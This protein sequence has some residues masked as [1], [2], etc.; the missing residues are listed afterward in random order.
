MPENH[1]SLLIYSPPWPHSMLNL[2]VISSIFNF[3]IYPRGIKEV[4]LSAPSFSPPCLR[5]GKFLRHGINRRKRE[6]TCNQHD[7]W[8]IYILF[9]RVRAWLHMFEENGCSLLP[10]FVLVFVYVKCLNSLAFS[11]SVVFF[12]LP[13]SKSWVPL[14]VNCRFSW[15]PKLPYILLACIKVDCLLVLS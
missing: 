7:G 9:K 13:N 6:I 14:Q 4:S 10:H 8:T 5:T 15:L 11:W 12:F 2:R 1:A 3:L